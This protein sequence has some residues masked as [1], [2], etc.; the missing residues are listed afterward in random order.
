MHYTYG[1]GYTLRTLDGEVVFYVGVWIPWKNLF[2]LTRYEWELFGWEGFGTTGYIWG[3]REGNFHLYGGEA[4]DTGTADIGELGNTLGIGEWLPDDSY[5][6]IKEELNFDG[7]PAAAALGGRL[8]LVY[9]RRDDPRFYTCR[10]V[11]ANDPGTPHMLDFDTPTVIP[12]DTYSSVPPSVCISRDYLYVFHVWDNQLFYRYQDSYGAWRPSGGSA[13]AGAPYTSLR[14]SAVALNNS[15]YLFFKNLDTREIIIKYA[16]R[17]PESSSYYQGD[18]FLNWLWHAALSGSTRTTTAPVATSDG[19]R[20]FVFSRGA[21]NHNLYYRASERN[22]LMATSWA[23][24]QGGS[25]LGN[26]ITRVSPAVASYADSIHIVSKGRDN[27]NAYH[28]SGTYRHP[29]KDD[30]G[31]TLYWASDDLL[32]WQDTKKVEGGNTVVKDSPTLVV[33]GPYLYLFYPCQYS[34]RV[35]YRAFEVK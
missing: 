27:D 10:A 28:R 6:H 29:V 19:S 24:S 31:N 32:T 7:A 17:S 25:K 16:E 21:E 34:G 11:S 13:S 30:E 23:P 14:P 18:G 9:K 4:Y 33:F 26:P 3:P 8:H 5:S 15:V 22:S 12:G 2:A 20:I 35:R 1:V